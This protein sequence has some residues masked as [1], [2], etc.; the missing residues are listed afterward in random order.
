VVVNEE[1]KAQIAL[2][3]KAV[4]GLDEVE[5][6]AVRKVVDHEGRTRSFEVDI[7]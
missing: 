2:Q 4:Y 7:R 1:D 6:V 5:V 3:V